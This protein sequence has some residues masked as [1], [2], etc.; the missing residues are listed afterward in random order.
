MVRI[1]IVILPDQRWSEAQRRWRQAEDWGF[2]HAW[3]YDHLGWRD[4]V[5][6]PWF[7]SMSTLTA[8]ALVTSRIRLG[9]LVASPNF[10]HPAAF[11]RQVTTLDDISNGRLLL[12]I[13]AGGIGFDATVL[14]RETLPPRRRVDRFGEFTELLDLLLRQDG[15]TW[16]GDWFSAVDARNNPG[17][18]QIP[19]VPFVVAANGPRSM[20]LVARFGQG[21][22]T[23]GAGGDDLESWWGSVAQASARLDATLDAAGR[24]PATLDRYLSLDAAPVFSLSSADFFT[25]A[26]GRAAA[27]GF[28]DVV[29][30]WPRLSSW[31]AGDEHVLAEVAERLAEL[32][33]L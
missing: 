21:W 1:G 19:R 24:D 4:L 30:H 26:V 12:G 3:T 16:R 5:D 15:V 25:E 10:R 17:C 33:R 2:D 22:V 27:L 9:T 18:V 23:T 13:G 14:G 32:R 29:T 7:D 8:A 20:R 6:G 31:Y 11:A 28:T